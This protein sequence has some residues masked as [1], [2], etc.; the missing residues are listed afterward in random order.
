[1]NVRHLQEKLIKSF[2]LSIFSFVDAVFICLNQICGYTDLCVEV[3]MFR[4]QPYSSEN[5]K[6]EQKLLEVKTLR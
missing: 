5:E 1:M 6:H 4:S 3:E 2:L